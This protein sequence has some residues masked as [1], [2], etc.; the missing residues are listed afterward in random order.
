MDKGVLISHIRLKQLRIKNFFGHC[1]NICGLICSLKL[2]IGKLKLDR[3][4]GCMCRRSVF[5]RKSVVWVLMTAILAVSGGRSVVA[6]TNFFPVSPSNSLFQDWSNVNLITFDDNWNN[7]PSIMGYRGDDANGAIGLNP[8]TVLPD[9]SSI[10]DV[11]ANRSDPNTFATGGIAEFDGIANPVVALLGSDSADFPSLVLHINGTSCVD[12]A[13]FVVSFTGRDIESSSDD[14]VQQIA[15]Q[16]RLG[17]TGNYTNIHSGYIFDAT[18][19]GV[20]V[21]NSFINAELPDNAK[22][23]PQIY[24]RILTANAA[25]NDEWVGIDNIRVSC[26]VPTAAEV[27]LGGRIMTADG[28]GLTNAKVSISGGDLPAPRLTLTGRSGAYSFEGLTAGESYIVTVNSR[29][30]VFSEPSRLV[31]LVDSV[32]NVDFVADEGKPSE[33]KL[34]NDSR[35]SFG[36]KRR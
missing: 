16:Y 13:K 15:V 2:Y 20:A 23:A 1:R 25:G 12:P 32:S 7:V 3:Q 22:G 33:S 19:G 14:A 24:V 21:R 11:N 10:I 35:E 30:F 5:F 29:R 17:P 28:R 4:E 8:E 36:F 18:D 6:N 31:N 34:I 9:Y 26:S 27:S